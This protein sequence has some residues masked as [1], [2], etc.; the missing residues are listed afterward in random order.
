MIR[1][2]IEQTPEKLRR[3]EEG[4]RERKSDLKSKI[5]LTS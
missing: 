2:F 3:R 1:G 5:M 4:K